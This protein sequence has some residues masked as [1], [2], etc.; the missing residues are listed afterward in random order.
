MDEKGD[1]A[2]ERA[3]PNYVEF[4]SGEDR[5]RYAL[6]TFAAPSGVR[7][8]LFY[9][10]FSFFLLSFVFQALV[11]VPMSF[12]DGKSVYQHMF[13]TE[14]QTWPTLN[15]NWLRYIE[16]S[17]SATVM[18]LAISLLAGINDLYLLL[19]IGTMCGACMWLG[20]C[21]EWMFRIAH[22]LGEDQSTWEH[23]EQIMRLC[24]YCCMITHLLGW[25]LLIVPWVV[26]IEA[27]RQWWTAR[28]CTV[29]GGRGEGTKPPEFVVAIIV[30][31][32]VL[33]LS[34][35][36][37]QV[38]SFWF[39]NATATTELMY[40]ALSLGAKTVLGLLVALNVFM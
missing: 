22:C 2:C 34:F 19:C 24:H 21:A 11:L 32:G 29:D 18:L 4:G 37:V 14:R 6:S 13:E 28:D 33:F 17:A 8:N 40:I 23:K 35:G 12:L 30:S 15:I 36:L 10:V 3:E 39:P 20:L 25:L 26:I 7:V 9:L 16:Y 1:G 5:A 38:Y 27:Y 31:Q